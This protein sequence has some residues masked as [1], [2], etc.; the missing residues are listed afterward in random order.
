[1]TDDDNTTPAFVPIDLSPE[2]QRASEVRDLLWMREHDKTPQYQIKNVM[3]EMNIRI[4]QYVAAFPNIS[5]ENLIAQTLQDFN[6]YILIK[7]KVIRIKSE[8][9]AL[10]RDGFK[11][12]YINPA[13]VRSDY[14]EGGIM[15][16]INEKV[17]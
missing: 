12:I 15:L 8:P 10:L 5:F 16:F 9:V 3:M 11:T 2:L 13:I 17:E 7:Q 1:M 6:Q 14:E 4:Q